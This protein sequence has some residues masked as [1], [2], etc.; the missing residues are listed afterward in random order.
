MFET[1]VVGVARVCRGLT[2]IDIEKSE[3][4]VCLEGQ[5]WATSDLSRARP[6]SSDLSAPV[7]VQ[8]V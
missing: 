3:E 1:R 4:V 8:V 2:A 5:Y 6:E 7:S